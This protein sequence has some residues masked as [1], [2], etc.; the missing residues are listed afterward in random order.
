M[1][2]KPSDMKPEDFVWHLKKLGYTLYSAPEL[3]PISRAM[4][5]NYANGDYPVSPV[6]AKPLRSLV[7]LEK[8]RVT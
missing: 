7:K 4:A 6:V 2:K 8:A 1:K 3:I 5:Y